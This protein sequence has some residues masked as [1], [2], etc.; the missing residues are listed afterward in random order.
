[1]E[2]WLETISP[3][4]L[5]CMN[6]SSTLCS[7]CSNNAPFWYSSC[8]R[9]KS[10]LFQLRS[11]WCSFVCLHISFFFEELPK[12]TSERSLTS[13]TFEWDFLSSPDLLCCFLKNAACFFSKISFTISFKAHFS[14]NDDC[15]VMNFRHRYKF[16]Y[17]VSIT[18]TE[19]SYANVRFQGSEAKK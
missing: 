3:T 10:S 12:R 18:T 14:Y 4:L 2:D 5:F 1:M 9:D 6:F 11:Q 15:L 17:P 8:K 7:R 16:Y 19:H 13:C